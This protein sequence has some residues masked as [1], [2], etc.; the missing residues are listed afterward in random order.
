VTTSALPR[1]VRSAVVAF[2]AACAA[3]IVV[4]PGTAAQATPSPAEIE[5]Q[6]DELWTQAEVTIE[7]YNS[8]HSK[9]RQNQTKLTK[10]KQQMS[11][12]QL[13]VE[14]STS[15]MGSL[16]AGMYMRG[17]GSTM[18]ALLTAGS[19]GVF[20]DQL[21]TLNQLAKHQNEAIASVREKVAQ[22]NVQ[23]K[24]L[25]LLVNQ[26]TQQ[27]ADLAAKKKDINAKLAKLQALRIQVYGTTAVGGVLKP[28]AC[29]FVYVGGAAATAVAY[30]C[31]QIGKPYL[32]GAD[33]PG[34][35]DCSGLTMRAWAAAG[36]YLPHNAADQ[37]RSVDYVS[38]A[39]VRTGDLV[40]F[41]SP[42]H[43]VGIY[44]GNGW[45]VHAPRSGDRVREARVTS[46]GTPSYGRP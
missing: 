11:P 10:L 38:S 43:H 21:T 39:N 9:L 28:V 23:R 14:L 26:L 1:S 2:I 15:Q 27:D 34:S 20:A 32:W 12:L 22:Y 8:V 3:L 33:G 25:D 40:F 18:N 16:A 31:R 19:P 13:Q 45:M 42:P 7:Q 44:I 36:V 6:M 24:P 46:V 41:G 30:A 4:L 17:P 29:P 37:K 5:R 35:F